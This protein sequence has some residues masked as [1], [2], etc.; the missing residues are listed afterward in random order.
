[1]CQGARQ[2]W[3]EKQTSK[4]KNEKQWQQQQKQ[5]KIQEKP[6]LS[7]QGTW[8]EEEQQKLGIQIHI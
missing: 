2:P 6:D 5:C 4:Q 3:T 8:K 7:D 1:M